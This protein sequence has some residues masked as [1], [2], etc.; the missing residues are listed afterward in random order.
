[1]NKLR[2]Q[3]EKIK[4]LWN[5]G[6]V[7]TIEGVEECLGKLNRIFSCLEEKKPDYGGE[8]CDE[9]TITNNESLKTYNKLGPYVYDPSVEK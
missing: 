5:Q 1:V 4:E 8:Y 7:S 9:P 3:Q 6:S 2:Q